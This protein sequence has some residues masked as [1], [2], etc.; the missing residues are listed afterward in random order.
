MNIFFKR[1]IQAF[2]IAEALS[3]PLIG[4]P[5]QQLSYIDTLVSKKS[6]T[7]KFSKSLIKNHLS[8]IVIG[9][10]SQDAETLLV[11]ENPRLDF[12]KALT[13]LFDNEFVNFSIQ[14]TNIHP[15]VQIA[16]SAIIEKG[17]KIGANSFIDHNVVIHAN[18]SIGERCIIRSNSVI[19]AEGFG[20]EKDVNQSWIRFPH[21]GKV[22]IGDNVEIG[23][24]NSICKGSLNDTIIKEGVKT[25]NL[26]HIG[27]NCSIEKNCILTACAEL[28]GGVSLGKS[29]WIGPNSS[30]ME[31]SI[32]VIMF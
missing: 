15:S 12:C 2:E 27:H 22:I 21:L 10:K 23:A 13:F 20:F 6:E 29:V 3:L 31:Q 28:S 30:I 16:S 7:L 14:E 1:K 19:G 18:T 26:V 25:D 4:D 24:L 5:N 32:L 17:V 8:G 9:D 11:S